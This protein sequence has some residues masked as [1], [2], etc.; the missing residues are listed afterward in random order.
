MR[1]ADATT[2]DPL[3]HLFDW[4]VDS[5]RDHVLSLLEDADPETFRSPST[6]EV[7]LV[8]LEHWNDGDCGDWEIEFLRDVAGNPLAKRMW[9][10]RRSARHCLAE[11]GIGDDRVKFHVFEVAG[12][13][14]DIAKKSGWIDK[15]RKVLVANQRRLRTVKQVQKA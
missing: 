10:L 11:H 7:G 5:K 2:N 6:D 9:E 15:N 4:W 12:R 14:G 3:L 1:S 8:L 13:L